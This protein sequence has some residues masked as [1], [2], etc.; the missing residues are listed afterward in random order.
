MTEH[1]DIR[2][3]VDHLFLCVFSYVFLHF[4]CSIEAFVH[5]LFWSDVSALMSYYHGHGH[6]PYSLLLWGPEFHAS[7][8][9]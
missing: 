2:P 3:M 6:L 9:S 5:V 7:F 1:H 8:A 4:V